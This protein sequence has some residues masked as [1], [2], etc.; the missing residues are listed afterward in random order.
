MAALGARGQGGVVLI[1]G[2][3]GMGKTRLLEEIKVGDEHHITFMLLECTA[4]GPL[5]CDISWNG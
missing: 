5:Y 3:P 2:D 4:L 1:E